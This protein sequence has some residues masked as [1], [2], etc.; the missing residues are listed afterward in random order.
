MVRQLDIVWNHFVPKMYEMYDKLAR[1][2]V[3]MIEGEV[4]YISREEVRDVW[5]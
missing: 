5:L 1:F 2:G 4:T 3:V